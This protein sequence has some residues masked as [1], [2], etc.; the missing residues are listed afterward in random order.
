[1][2]L[3][4]YDFQQKLSEKERL[5]DRRLQD[6]D[7]DINVKLVNREK[8]VVEAESKREVARTK[9]QE[10]AQVDKR[11]AEA[12]FKVVSVRAQQEK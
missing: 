9:A 10:N 8:E 4:Q 3:I 7:A 6:I 5:Y 11:R 1:M 12:E 2:K